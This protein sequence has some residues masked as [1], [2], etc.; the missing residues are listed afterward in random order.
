MPAFPKPSAT[1]TDPVASPLVEA[2]AEDRAAADSAHA[3][4]ATGAHGG[5]VASAEKGAANGVAT[6]GADGKILDA[7]LGQLAITD[8]FTVAS[9]AA[10]LALTAERGDVAIRSDLNTSF[11]LSASPASTLA[12]WK[13]LLTPTDVVTSVNGRQ[14]VV[15]GLAEQTAVTAVEGLAGTKVGGTTDS[16]IDAKGDLTV[17]TA[18]NTR[19]RKAV[20]ADGR[21]LRA[22]SAS[23]DGLEWGG[24]TAQSPADH[25][26]LAWSFD[27]GT[28]YS[29]GVAVGLGTRQYVRVPIPYTMTLSNL[30]TY[31]TSA[32]SALTSGQCLGAV[33]SSAGVLLGKTATQHT[34]WQSPGLKSMALTAEAGQSLTVA[35]GYVIAALLANGTTAPQFPDVVSAVTQWNLG[36]STPG[37]S[38]H[39]DGGG[40]ATS[41]A[42]TLGTTTANNTYYWWMAFS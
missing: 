2:E 26:W 21:L 33:Y 30:V 6:L 34:A 27:L 15:T 17:G 11:I 40:S 25:G 32:G 28:M 3:A 23:S 14:G 18:D 20:G 38:S 19:A 22:N 9:Q 10:M 35:P 13:E 24:A 1:E 42:S 39:T 5:I 8:V 7:Q 36:Q 29:T 31:V 12:N 37:F 16:L 4:L 41:F